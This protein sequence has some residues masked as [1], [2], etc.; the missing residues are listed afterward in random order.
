MY[1]FN[2]IRKLQ[3]PN[4]IP[5]DKTWQTFLQEKIRSSSNP[6]VPSESTENNCI[7][8]DFRPDASSLQ[9]TVTDLLNFRY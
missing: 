9:H 8:R 7:L 3:T 1:K 5:N 6:C 4:L 2:R